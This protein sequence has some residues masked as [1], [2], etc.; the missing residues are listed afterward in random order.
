MVSSGSRRSGKLWRYLILAFCV[1]CA[2]AVVI[3]LYA[4]NATASPKAPDTV[5]NV[6]IVGS[7]PFSFDPAVITVTA[8]TSVVWTNQTFA[9]H[10]VTSDISDTQSFDSG[11]IAPG[12]TYTYTFLISGT[13][14]YHCAIHTDM[15]GTVVVVGPSLTQ[16]LDLPIVMQ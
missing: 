3:A 5:A 14:P 8:G 13:F 15:H 11:G 16:T 7:F 10:T 9:T 1:L 6:S 4:F 12:G 2:F